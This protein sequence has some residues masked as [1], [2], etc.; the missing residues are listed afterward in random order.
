MIRLRRSACPYPDALINGDYKHPRNK[1][2]LKD[3][4]NGKCMYCE[5]KIMHV[6]FGDVEHIKPKSP[7]H[8]PELEFEWT[9]LGFICDRCNNAKGKKYFSGAQ[10]INPY[11]EDPKNEIL[12]YGSLILSRKG[13]ERGEIT[14]NEIDL[15][16]GDL[17]ERRNMRILSIQR[18]L[19]AALRATDADV[20]LSAIEQLKQEALP[21]KEFSLAIST[22]LESQDL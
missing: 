13:S 22:F 15:N 21:D 4:T 14:I 11:D 12:A 1:Q 3:S 19:V 16:R 6:N 10:F 20:R 9:N 5:S 8:F 2:A 17:V 7:E 18:A